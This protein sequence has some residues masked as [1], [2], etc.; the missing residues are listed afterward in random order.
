LRAIPGLVVVRPADA[1]E[2]VDAWRVALERTDGPTALVLSRQDL[3]PVSAAAGAPRATRGAYVV[4]DHG[5]AGSPPDVL[6][7]GSG[8]EV[9]L[10]IG[11]ADALAD[12]GVA[13]RVVSMPSWEGFLDQPGDYRDAVLPPGVTAR[14]VVE[15]AA[16]TGW[17]R[18]AGDRGRMV[19]L[20]RFGASA[21]GPVA[22]AELGFTPEAVA[23]AAR[24]AI[25]AAR[26]ARGAGTRA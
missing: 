13:A 3:A 19:T 4:A 24:D 14:V 25:A 2:T 7:I 11:A 1:A 22:Q 9:A 17:E 6:L 20:D 12:E 10:A 18:F 5:T 16:S 15:A 8:S 23:A 26:A 21:P